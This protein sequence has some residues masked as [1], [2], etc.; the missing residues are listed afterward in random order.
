MR[1]KTVPAVDFE[2]SA[3]GFGCWAAGGSSVWNDSDDDKTIRAIQRAVE[4]GITFFDVAPVYGFGHAETMLGKALGNQRQQV[5]IASKCGLRWDAQGNIVNDLSPARIQQEI[6]DSLRRLNTDYIDIYQMHWPDPNTPIGE[7]MQT[8]L[9]IQEAGKIR[10][11]GVSNFSARLMDEARQHGDIVSHQGLYNMLERNPVQYHNIP[12]DYRTEKETLPYCQEHG[13][14]FFPYS[15]LFQGL[16]TDNFKAQ[17]QFDE[18]DVRSANP[19]LNGESFQAFYEIRQKLLAFAQEI[20]KP[21]SQVAINWLIEQPAV[22]SVICGAQSVAHVEENAGS[23]DWTL[24]ADSM[25]QIENI[26]QPYYERIHS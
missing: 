21:L 23:A 15:P 5:I 19:K 6:D 12:L 17:G 16:L 3:V 7:T 8:L 1:M 20:G 9:Q 24:S 14:A 4:L 2:F 10:H 25:A 13:M 22:T 26:L 18:N 11:I